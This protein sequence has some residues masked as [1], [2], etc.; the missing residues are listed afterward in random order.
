M[1]LASSGRLSARGAR[2]GWPLRSFG[3]RGPLPVPP[4][5]AAGLA[6]SPPPP[7][8]LHAA[9]S[10]ASAVTAP[11]ADGYGA[12]SFPAS[13]ASAGSQHFATACAAD[14]SGSPFP[15]SGPVAS[16][17][18]SPSRRSISC[19]ASP[20]CSPQ[21]FPCAPEALLG[22]CVPL[23]P[24][25]TRGKVNVSRSAAS[26]AS[27]AALPPFC[28][29]VAAVSPLVHT[30]S[31]CL[32]PFVPSASPATRVPSGLEVSTP[33]DDSSSGRTSFESSP[34]SSA[35]LLSG[36]TRR[37]LGGGSPPQSAAAGAAVATADGC[38]SREQVAACLS[39]SSSFV[40][41]AAYHDC[42]QLRC[43]YSC[44]YSHLSN[45]VFLLHVPALLFV[46]QCAR[47]SPP[48]PGARLD[49]GQAR[50]DSS[51]SLLR[52]C[53]LSSF[54]SS[55]SAP[56]APRQY[57]E[58]GRRFKTRVL[59]DGSVGSF[60]PECATAAWGPQGEFAQGDEGRLA[61]S[62]SREVPRRRRSYVRQLSCYSL[63]REGC[64]PPPLGDRGGSPW[65]LAPCYLGDSRG[66]ALS[67]EELLQA[68][69]DGRS[70]HSLPSS[71]LEA[72][73]G[74]R[75]LP[76]ALTAQ[77]SPLGDTFLSAE[78]A[79]AAPP[80]PSLLL[81]LLAEV[82]PAPFPSLWPPLVLLLQK[83]EGSDEL[84]SGGGESRK[85]PRRRTPKRVSPPGT[86]RGHLSADPDAS[87]V[88]LREPPTAGAAGALSRGA[89]SVS[90]SAASGVL[91]LGHAYAM[92]V[93]AHLGAV[94]S[95]QLHSATA[96][97]ALLLFAQVEGW[98][99][100]VWREREPC[101]GSME[102][103]VR[104]ELP[105]PSPA[106][107]PLSRAG[108]EAPE[109]GEL[110][111]GDDC[112][113]RRRKIGR[114]RP[115][116]AA[117]AEEGE[118]D[119]RGSPQR[120]EREKI[121]KEQGTTWP[122][123][124]D[125]RRVARV[126][127]LE[128]D[129][130]TQ[131]LGGSGLSSLD[132]GLTDSS[133]FAA[134]PRQHILFLYLAAEPRLESDVSFFFPCA[135][136][137]RSPADD[138][139]GDDDVEGGDFEAADVGEGRKRCRGRDAG[140][141]KEG[142]RF[143]GAFMV[144]GLA[145]GA[146]GR[147]V[148]Q[149]VAGPA[150][151]P[152]DATGLDI[153]EIEKAELCEISLMTSFLTVSSSSSCPPV[154]SG[155]VV[156]APVR[157]GLPLSG[158]S[159]SIPPLI[160]SCQ[161]PG[162]STHRPASSATASAS[163]AVAAVGGNLAW[164]ELTGLL[165]SAIPPCRL[166]VRTGAR[167]QAVLLVSPLFL[168]C[169]PEASPASRERALPRAADRAAGLS[170][171]EP[172][173]PQ[174]P[175]CSPSAGAAGWAACSPQ[176][177][178]PVGPALHYSLRCL[179]S[180]SRTF[181]PAS[182][183][184]RASLA[185]LWPPFMHA[186]LLR[187]LSSLA[188][189]V[190]PSALC[191]LPLQ[192]NLSKASSTVSA[193]P[194]PKQSL[195]L[196]PSS[197]LPL[198]SSSPCLLAAAAGD[199]E[200]A[201]A[202]PSPRGG[203]APAAQPLGLRSPSL[204]RGNAA[205]AFSLSPPSRLLSPGAA[206]V[207]DAASVTTEGSGACL[208]DLG[209][210]PAAP[211]G[212]RPPSASVS[213]S[214]SG[215]RAPPSFL[216]L[217][218][219]P[220][221][222]VAAGLVA[223]PAWASGPSG[224]EPR[225]V[226]F[227][228]HYSDMLAGSPPV[229]CLQSLTVP[230]GDPGD[231]FAAGDRRSRNK[232][233]ALKQ[234]YRRLPLMSAVYWLP[235][236]SLSLF[237][238]ACRDSSAERLSPEGGGEEATADVPLRFF[239]R[240]GEEA[241]LRNS[242]IG[243][244]GGSRRGGALDMIGGQLPVLVCVAAE[245]LRDNRGTKRAKSGGRRPCLYVFEVDLLHS[246]FGIR[247]VSL[248]F[249][250]APG[251]LP[252]PISQVLPVSSSR[253]D[254]SPLPSGG[255]DP[256]KSRI[257][258]S[259][260]VVASQ[261]LELSASFLSH[262][263]RSHML[264]VLLV[265]E[266]SEAVARA[267]SGCVQTDFVS[268]RGD[269]ACE[270]A[271][272]SRSADRGGP[273]DAEQALV[274]KRTSS[275]SSLVS[276]LLP[277]SYS[278]LVYAI[279]TPRSA[280]GGSRPPTAR[281]EGGCA[282]SGGVTSE[283]VEAGSGCSK[284][285][286]FVGL[287]SA[288]CLSFE[289]LGRWS[290]AGC[291][292]M[293]AAFGGYASGKPVFSACV[294]SSS[295]LLLASPLFF[296]AAASAGTM[297]SQ[298]ALLSSAP[299]QM[300]SSGALLAGAAAAHGRHTAGASIEPEASGKTDA[301]EKC[302]LFLLQ[303]PKPPSASQ[304]RLREAARGG[305]APS[306]LS[307]GDEEDTETP[308][309]LHALSRLSLFAVAALPRDRRVTAVALAPDSLAVGTSFKQ[310]ANGGGGG[311][312]P[313]TA[314]QTRVPVA[315]VFGLRGL[316]LVVP[317]SLE[318]AGSGQSVASTPLAQ[319][320]IGAES[321]TTLA[322]MRAA[323]AHASQLQPEAA[324]PL[325]GFAREVL[326][327]DQSGAGDRAAGSGTTSSLSASSAPR[328]CK[329]FLHQSVRTTR[330]AAGPRA[331][332]SSAFGRLSS[333]RWRT[334]IQTLAS[335]ADAGEEQQH[336]EL[337][338]GPN[339]DQMETGA[340]GRPSGAVSAVQ[341]GAGCALP[342]SLH[343]VV[344]LAFC[345]L[346]GAALGLLAKTASPQAAQGRG[347]QQQGTGEG[348]MYLFVCVSAAQ[349]RRASGFGTGACSSAAQRM[350][351]VW[352]R[353]LPLPPEDCLPPEAQH[354]AFYGHP[355][356]SGL[357]DAWWSSEPGSLLAFLALPPSAPGAADLAAGP[358]GFGSVAPWGEDAG[359]TSGAAAGSAPDPL[360]HHA[361]G[362]LCSLA[363]S[364]AAA[365][366]AAACSWDLRL[367]VEAD[368]ARRRERNAS[369]SS[370]DASLS[371]QVLG[372][373]QR[374]SL[375]SLLCFLLPIGARP[376]AP[377]SG[378]PSACL[379]HAKAHERLHPPTASGLV[380]PTNTA[381]ATVASVASPAAAARAA[382][383][384]LA[385]Q[386]EHEEAE[387]RLLQ[388]VS[389]PLLLLYHPAVLD[390]L[391]SSG[392]VGTVKWILGTLL[393][394]LRA[395]GVARA[396]ESLQRKKDGR[397]AENASA[398][399][400]T[401]ILLGGFMWESSSKGPGGG[402][403]S[404]EC[405]WDASPPD[406]AD[407]G[408]TPGG[409]GAATSE[410]LEGAE[411]ACCCCGDRGDTE[412]CSCCCV[413]QTLLDTSMMCLSGIFLQ[414]AAEEHEL[415]AARR[416]GDSGKGGSEV[417]STGF[418]SRGAPD[419]AADCALGVGS[420]VTG[421]GHGAGRL[422][423]AAETH[424]PE[425]RREAFYAALL[426]RC[427]VA[428]RGLV[429][430]ME[431]V[432][433]DP[434][435]DAD[436]V[437]G[438]TSE[439]GFRGSDV[440]SGLG[441]VRQQ[442]PFEFGG[443][444]SGAAARKE[445]GRAEDLFGSSSSVLED[446]DPFDV[447]DL[448]GLGGGKKKKEE[449][450]SLFSAPRDYVTSALQHQ[451]Q[452][453]QGGASAAP[454]SVSPCHLS[455]T[456]LDPVVVAL[457]PADYD[458]LL[459]LLGV[460][461]PGLRLTGP[462]RRHLWGFVAALRSLEGGQLER[463]ETPVNSLL[464]DFPAV[465]AA[466]FEAA[467]AA[468][469]ALA[470]GVAKSEARPLAD[471]EGARGFV[472]QGFGCRSLED[473]STPRTA[474]TQD[475][476]PARGHDEV[477]ERENGPLTPGDEEAREGELAAA[478]VAADKLRGRT[479]RAS[480][481]AS[482]GGKRRK[483]G[484]LDKEAC[485]ARARMG[486]LQVAVSEEAA[487]EVAEQQ[488][489]AHQPLRAKLAMAA[490]LFTAPEK[491]SPVS[492]PE[493]G[494]SP[495]SLLLSSEDL[496]WCLQADGEG[497][498]LAEAVAS[499]RKS[500]RGKLLWPHI[501]KRGVGFWLRSTTQVRALGDWLLKDATVLAAAETAAQQG[502]FG[503]PHAGG[504]GDKET[505]AL[506][507]LSSYASSASVQMPS[508]DSS[509][510]AV[511]PFHRSD[512]AAL[513]S[514][515]S[516]RLSFIK[517]AYKQQKN[518]KVVE[519]LS[520]DFSDPRAQAAAEKNAYKLVQQRRYHLALAFFILAKKIREVCDLCCRQLQD[521][522]LALFL[523]R[524]IDATQRP[525]GP[526]LG[527][528]PFSVSAS[529]FCSPSVAS[530]HTVAASPG[531]LGPRG[532]KASSPSALLSLPPP[533][534]GALSLSP[535]PLPSSPPTLSE[536]GGAVAHGGARSPSDGA[537]PLASSSSS[538][539]PLTEYRRVLLQRLAPLA[540]EAG[541]VWLLHLALWL[542]GDYQAALFVLL[543]PHL[544]PSF[545]RLA[546]HAHA[547]PP[548]AGAS[549]G[550]ADAVSVPEGR[551][552]CWLADGSDVSAV[553][554]FHPRLFFSACEDSAVAV[555]PSHLFERLP[556]P[557]GALCPPGS[558]QGV[559]PARLGSGQPKHAP[560]A[561]R[562]VF[563]FLSHVA[564]GR[565]DAGERHTAAHSGPHADR[566]DG[567]T[568][569]HSQLSLSLV[570]F[571][572]VVLNTLP[573]QRLRAE[574][575]QQHAQLQLVR[576]LCAQLQSR[577][578]APGSQG[579]NSLSPSAARQTGH[580][581]A[582]GG[583]DGGHA[584]A[585]RPPPNGGERLRGA[586]AP[587][588][589]GGGASPVESPRGGS[590]SAPR[591]GSGTFSL[592]SA[593]SSLGSSPPSGPAHGAAQP[594]F[595]LFHHSSASTLDALS[596]TTR[597][598]YSDVGTGAGGSGTQRGPRGEG[599]AGEEA[600]DGEDGERG[601][602]RD[603]AGVG[604]GG[605]GAGEP[606]EPGLSRA[607]SGW[608]AP[609][610][611]SSPPAA[612]PTE[613]LDL[614]VVGRAS[615]E[616]FT[617]ARVSR[618]DRPDAA[619]GV[620][621][622][623]EL[624]EAACV[625]EACLWALKNPSAAA[626]CEF[627]LLTLAYLHQRQAFLAS[628]ASASFLALARV[629]DG[630]VEEEA[631]KTTRRG[632][633]LGARG[634]E[635]DAV[636]ECGGKRAAA[637]LTGEGQEPHG[638][639]ERLS[640]ATDIRMHSFVARRWVPTAQ[641]AFEL[642]FASW[643][644]CLTMD[645]SLRST[646][647]AL[648]IRVPLPEEI[649]TQK[650]EAG[651]PASRSSS[652]CELT[653][654]NVGTL[655]LLPESP[656]ASLL[657]RLAAPEPCRSC[658]LCGVSSA[659]VGPSASR[660]TVSL[661][662][663]D[664]IASCLVAFVGCLCE[665]ADFLR[666]VLD[667]ALLSSSSLG[668][669]GARRSA[670]AFPCSPRCVCCRAG[671]AGPS[672]EASP[673]A[674]H[675][676][677]LAPSLAAAP[678]PSGGDLASRN[679]SVGSVRAASPNP[680]R[681][682]GVLDAVVSQLLLWS[683]RRRRSSALAGLSADAAGG[684]VRRRGPA[685]CSCAEKRLLQAIQAAEKIGGGRRLTA[686]AAGAMA[687]AA[688]A[689]P[690]AGAVRE[691]RLLRRLCQCGEGA[692][693][694]DD[695]SAED[696]GPPRGR[697]TD[698]ACSGAA[699]AAGGT[700]QDASASFSSLEPPLWALAATFGSRV[701][702][703]FE[704]DTRHLASGCFLAAVRAAALG[705]RAAAAARRRT[706]TPSGGAE[707]GASR[708]AVSRRGRR[709]AWRLA[710][711]CAAA[712]VRSEVL[713]DLSWNREVQTVLHTYLDG[714]DEA[715]V[716]A[717]SGR[718]GASPRNATLWGMRDALERGEAFS[719]R[720]AT[721][722]LAKELIAI[723]SAPER[724]LFDSL[725]IFCCTAAAAASLDIASALEHALPVCPRAGEGVE[726]RAGGAD[727]L[728]VCASC[729]RHR[730]DRADSHALGMARPT[731]AVLSLEHLERL[732]QLSVVALGCVC[733]CLSAAFPSL[734]L[735]FSLHPSTHTGAH[736]SSPSGGGACGGSASHLSAD[737]R[738]GHEERAY[739]RSVSS[740][741][742]TEAAE[743][744]AE[745][746]GETAKAAEDKGAPE[747]RHA[748]H[749]DGGDEA[750]D[751]EFNP[752]G[753]IL[754]I[755]V[756]LHCILMQPKRSTWVCELRRH[757]R[758]FLWPRAASCARKNS[759]AEDAESSRTGSTAEDA[760]GVS[761]RSRARRERDAAR[762]RKSS[763]AFPTSS[764]LL[765]CLAACLSVKVFEFLLDLLRA[766][767][768][769]ALRLLHFFQLLALASASPGGESR[770]A[771]PKDGESEGEMPL[772]GRAE[773]VA[774]G[775]LL[776]MSSFPV[777]HLS[778]ALTPPETGGVAAAGHQAASL[779]LQE[780]QIRLL[781]GW[782]DRL[783]FSLSSFV[784]SHL[785]PLLTR[786]APLSASL[787]L[788]LLCSSDPPSL[789]GV[790]GLE[791][792]WAR[793]ETHEPA[794]SSRSFMDNCF[795]L[796]TG[797]TKGPL[798]CRSIS[799]LLGPDAA[800][801]WI[802]LGC[803]ARLQWLFGQLPF[804]PL[805]QPLP[806]S[807]PASPG[808]SAPSHA[809][810]QGTAKGGSATGAGS[811]AHLGGGAVGETFQKPAAP[812]ATSRAAR[813]DAPLGG[814]EGRGVWGSAGGRTGKKPAVVVGGATSRMQLQQQLVRAGIPHL[815][816][817]EGR[818]QVVQK[819]GAGSGP[820]L[821]RLQQHVLAELPSLRLADE[822]VV[823]GAAP[824]VPCVLGGVFPPGKICSVAASRPRTNAVEA[825]RKTYEHHLPSFLTPEAVALLLAEAV[826]SQR[827][828]RSAAAETPVGSSKPA[829]N[830]AP[831]PF[832]PLSSARSLPRASRPWGT[833]P[834][835]WWSSPCCWVPIA[836]VLGPVTVAC[837]GSSH[838]RYFLPAGA[839][840]STDLAVGVGPLEGLTVTGGAGGAA[841]NSS[842]ALRTIRIPP[843]L[844][845]AS[846][847]GGGA[848]TASLLYGAAAAVHAAAAATAAVAA[849]AE[850]RGDLLLL[851]P[852]KGAPKAV[853][854]PVED[855]EE[856]PGSR[857]AA[858]G[859]GSPP[860]AP[861]VGSAEGAPG[862]PP[863][864]G[865][866]EQVDPA[867]PENVKEEGEAS[868]PRGG[869]FEAFKAEARWLLSVTSPLMS[870]SRCPG[871][872]FVGIAPLRRATVNSSQH[873]Q[874]RLTRILARYRHHR[875]ETDSRWPGRHEASKRAP[876]SPGGG[877][878]AALVET[879]SLLNAS[880]SEGSVLLSVWFGYLLTRDTSLFAYAQVDRMSAAMRL[881]AVAAAA[882]G[883]ASR[884]TPP[885]GS[886]APGLAS[887]G[888][889]AGGAKDLAVSLP[890]SGGL[891]HPA[892]HPRASLAASLE[893]TFPYQAFPS[894]SVLRSCFSFTG[895]VSGHPFLPIFAAVLQAV[896][897]QA[898]PATAFG[899]ILRPFGAHARSLPKASSP[900]LPESSREAPSTASGD[901]NGRQ[902]EPAEAHVGARSRPSGFEAAAHAESSPRGDQPE[903]TGAGAKAGEGDS[904][905]SGPSSSVLRAGST[906]ANG[907]LQRVQT[908]QLPREQ[909]DL[910][911]FAR[912]RSA[913]GSFPF[914]R[915]AIAE[916]AKAAASSGPPGSGRGAAASAAGASASS[917]GGA[918]AGSASRGRPQ[919][920]L[921]CFGRVT[922]V[923]W[924]ESGDSLFM[925]DSTGWIRV[926]GLLRGPLLPP[927]AAVAVAAAGAESGPSSRLGI[928]SAS[929]RGAGHHHHV[930]APTPA[931][932]EGMLS[933]AVQQVT[934]PAVAWRGH[935]STE[936]VLPLHGC[937]SWLLTRGVGLFPHAV[938]HNPVLVEGSPF[939][940]GAEGP[941]LGLPPAH[942]KPR[943]GAAGAA[944]HADF[945]YRRGGGGGDRDG[946]RDSARRSVS[947]GVGRATGEGRRHAEDDD[948]AYEEGSDEPGAMS[949]DSGGALL[950]HP[951]RMSVHNG[952]SSTNSA[953]EGGNLGARL[954]IRHPTPPG[955]NRASMVV[956]QLHGQQRAGG[957]DS[958]DRACD[959]TRERRRHGLEVPESPSGTSGD[960]K[961]WR[962]HN[963]HPFSIFR[964]GRG[965]GC[966]EAADAAAAGGG[967][968]RLRAARLAL[969]RRDSGSAE[970]EKEGAEDVP[971]GAARRRRSL[972][973]LPSTARRRFKGT[974]II[975]KI[976]A[977]LAQYQTQ[978]QQ[979]YGSSQHLPRKASQRAAGGAWHVEPSSGVE[980]T[981]SPPSSVGGVSS[982]GYAYAATATSGLIGPGGFQASL[983]S[984]SALYSGSLRSGG[985]LG[986]EED[987][988]AGSV[989]ALSSTLPLQQWTS[990]V[991]S[992][993][994]AGE[995]SEDEE[996]RLGVRDRLLGGDFQ[997]MPRISGP[998]ICLWDLWDITAGGGPRLDC[999]I[1000]CDDL[1001]L[1002]RV[1003][1004]QLASA[1005]GSKSSLGAP[1006]SSKRASKLKKGSQ[1007]A[1008]G[1009]VE[1010]S[1011]ETWEVVAT[1012]T[1013]TCMGVAVLQD[1014]PEVCSCCSAAASGG[1015]GCAAPGAEVCGAAWASRAWGSGRQADATACGG[1016]PS[1017]C[1018]AGSSCR[1019]CSWCCGSMRC[1020]LYGDADGAVHAVD[1021]S[1022]Q[1023]EVYRWQ[1024]HP[1025]A[1026]V[1027]C[1028]VSRPAAA[1029]PSHVS[1030]IPAS[1031][1032]VTAASAPA[1033]DATFRC[1034]SLSALQGGPPFLLYEFTSPGHVPLPLGAAGA[1035]GRALGGLVGTQTAG[1036]LRDEGAAARFGGLGAGAGSTPGVVVGSV[1037]S[1038][1039]Q[1040]RRMLGDETWQG[1041]AGDRSDVVQQG[1042]QPT[1043]SVS[1044][1045][1046][1047]FAPSSVNALVR[1048]L[1049]VEG[1050]EAKASPA[1051]AQ[1052]D[1053]SVA[1054]SQVVGP[1055]S[1056]LTVRQDGIV[1057]LNRL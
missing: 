444:S 335:H 80:A 1039:P 934:R 367:C 109:D 566:F 17:P 313:A 637:A 362:A 330:G 707:T 451:S 437:P 857:E 796:P 655:L 469:E 474:V 827:P 370:A 804:L 921:Q 499:A 250:L 347:A 153:V 790:S 1025:S 213:S 524:L 915:T 56:P 753:T 1019:C 858:A 129:E 865:L 13:V 734:A 151:V 814:G 909:A 1013:P 1000:T 132:F 209:R 463:G 1037:N 482:Q 635:R 118:G 850:Y 8:S 765:Q 1044:P 684:G 651:S 670:T 471:R 853:S 174:L 1035:R 616:S 632:Q 156:G 923:A 293:R 36:G 846:P 562:P 424:G 593:P 549:R 64:A 764:S 498:M 419:Q 290:A 489:A 505:P 58:R 1003:Q 717:R 327:K 193:L 542:A 218:V 32:V 86:P 381:A 396:R 418:S 946:G 773:T 496:C 29:T 831:P 787:L 91:I 568:L 1040:E 929:S 750:A 696:C 308:F 312:R 977:R 89:A 122:S 894:L 1012:H 933:A 477:P 398:G 819:Q 441:S 896:E 732:L 667:R 211:T 389:P 282:A 400:E 780:R 706:G 811:P 558:A 22:A 991:F 3:A 693:E 943:A 710:R 837:C 246:L 990:G 1052:A 42:A 507:S 621:S 731:S 738:V 493:K 881:L 733:L 143:I 795:V 74:P 115:D 851:A 588:A 740:A 464:T 35:S 395:A 425:K 596:D 892:G 92:S 291:A 177:S 1027:A 90:A 276:R 379:P 940:S 799:V 913:A 538:S 450:M 781:R 280:A 310:V 859:S 372:T 570:S 925:A 307:R 1053:E 506:A 95:V 590:F 544:P 96:C 993:G 553:A 173:R 237:Q 970:M 907:F 697:A 904:Q 658:F 328:K 2:A 301:G 1005:T 766:I 705:R 520:R 354:Q 838:R 28:V 645:R 602:R 889:P 168:C 902:P 565:A 1031:W 964:R 300:P 40:Y 584:A 746:A 439:G 515:A 65:P 720:G 547:P 636:F 360:P 114:R 187:P 447:S 468:A 586:G 317:V 1021:L 656:I 373:I 359:D 190:T 711:F 930:A 772:Q 286:A 748:Q 195:A 540:A 116:G 175:R 119:L 888:A 369:V 965:K 1023:E 409:A 1020:V 180:V 465:A 661:S 630:G 613:D 303:L 457:S 212:K 694:S 582:A 368:A 571:R 998:C 564:A 691:Q 149:R 284:A 741:A 513:W 19:V 843:I 752:L 414:L 279:G 862:A 4:P 242:G 492:A 951:M 374:F 572:A 268:Q 681:A 205:S 792:S 747:A 287:R 863:E 906:A 421:R 834:V 911:E 1051:P 718:P 634:D 922:C 663:A 256:P 876:S 105:L 12:L 103:A 809:G 627:Y 423:G 782:V 146:V 386:R 650:E 802:L 716:R 226:V 266:R 605:L 657:S 329:S 1007:A 185:S 77:S 494:S 361:P 728:F 617:P 133:P 702:S 551:T 106:A 139:E 592:V 488:S 739:Q 288:G 71:L 890:G 82:L 801:L 952:A 640:D 726:N 532:L 646:D 167:D 994:G 68:D 950:K 595:H 530:A 522:Q 162:L 341:E 247:P 196:P 306:V 971:L 798:L 856:L 908:T 760:Q 33:G 722:V 127:V 818:P 962:G 729:S 443:L 609:H 1041:R 271:S 742:A 960:A 417:R 391:F 1049:G 875:S 687:W 848:C 383:A 504:D 285:D 429:G 85:D 623:V 966:C 985:G 886:G 9:L 891:A 123:S 323:V 365:A 257:R 546:S 758:D 606:A 516:D 1033:A 230:S 583:V 402:E 475:L 104:I 825:L 895:S 358:D 364:P 939:V 882:S 1010:S 411:A 514:V 501:K 433:D 995:Q 445:G 432:Q 197:G 393:R 47:P 976:Q 629:G 992:F 916:L 770:A 638:A 751:R 771:S 434:P 407:A 763:H 101:S 662:L 388:L 620:A 223:P 901:A 519:F 128:L 431:N 883:G 158:L 844:L 866:T 832:T 947:V 988:E 126:A 442:S 302:F 808:V 188:S 229:C 430:G 182:L 184:S 744:D 189:S 97:T 73:A 567:G 108:G 350:P 786:A 378:A 614:R 178:P 665:D 491:P 526:P 10:S 512:V 155:V 679:S 255:S 628:V 961:A 724:Q 117:D 18:H 240:G 855:A 719:A 455:E 397:A 75:A 172:D 521:V 563:P 686:I 1045:F 377:L 806:P 893:P 113:K 885:S 784:C 136:A 137:R 972:R 619:D 762:R 78:S 873:L 265:E 937:G 626:A 48:S 53:S 1001:L 1011:G 975:A 401:T 233:A 7:S 461:V 161:Q 1034:W 812:G 479:L 709:D 783:S 660:R 1030:S 575:E 1022:L 601:R 311:E 840:I 422:S 639:G 93:C 974:D 456:S 325:L 130:R 283:E 245:E 392:L 712:W 723:F 500:A 847:S 244:E 884:S 84:E 194:A 249:S 148:V 803:T 969:R 154:A 1024:A 454:S 984:G 163:A 467:G 318:T 344:R 232:A 510:A 578:V 649:F 529:L 224:E 228:W 24:A 66:W 1036:T 142:F 690:V 320:S 918:A 349:L 472:A 191:L 899:V 110:W 72:G 920:Q 235:A 761:S 573:I 791:A 823:S 671:L 299:S 869:R 186:G 473:R 416:R 458:L 810:G 480:T 70:S 556:S 878:P 887:P 824:G 642:L 817:S 39:L 289:L 633:C 677:G 258:F 352:L 346:P 924:S 767:D 683:D 338:K 534:S 1048:L 220:E 610:L 296:H 874:R 253:L 315:F 836:A 821:S 509:S 292:D 124:R 277:A 999:V 76:R 324:L 241:P 560:E 107:A 446:D 653:G 579:G 99:V 533:S 917:S 1055:A 497:A 517:T 387:L 267:S 98:G 664:A 481:A 502:A 618:S 518:T 967:V 557:L 131:G 830:G 769:E 337:A 958:A 880:W 192:Q 919:G 849:A 470:G 152:L 476:A 251:S 774:F 689:G 644:P 281:P 55:P 794:R 523:C 238:R 1042:Q 309:S 14:S 405:P 845:G 868:R 543:P 589:L 87:Q 503:A 69:E 835:P 905:A 487:V 234:R 615:S 305:L 37:A 938:R 944:G 484:K 59:A 490:S 926:Y 121:C 30:S 269:S 643:A 955:R 404:A 21:V 545:A 797:N 789:G 996:E 903:E 1050:R 820:A 204:S 508:S 176:A 585:L 252:W 298:S 704:E 597:G 448:L 721:A 483:G 208:Q 138:G 982:S 462:E 1054:M 957:R 587:Q 478:R 754:H 528:D 41:A 394:C 535:S 941:A 1029:C 673:P 321:R 332:L 217:E 314:P 261:A 581:A 987:S 983:S 877:F 603:A 403:V 541:D 214:P 779:R 554:P 1043:Q 166:T 275:A 11:H 963:H 968:T 260:R 672:E 805:Q 179:S 248:S 980:A 730:E 829:G 1057:L 598:D 793:E 759:A 102:L 60:P 221:F 641:A 79:A 674:A 202:G 27:P 692:D 625:G 31:A 63:S 833:S 511:N 67:A 319:D 62:P 945:V 1014:C 26:S 986:P 351:P 700:Q 822:L 222:N 973:M 331:G 1006:G 81:S 273:Q 333:R 34:P 815:L 141:K 867:R 363:S 1009:G 912:G 412:L 15:V 410:A 436:A 725:A 371:F 604:H 198:S 914:D 675:G 577:P 6:G 262:S 550:F 334:Q 713:L 326:H 44:I 297:H 816:L 864:T 536:A 537:A 685:G 83:L 776:K 88:A 548:G 682:L 594:P 183:A 120:R 828:H 20:A 910:S 552:H 466:A 206:S 936:E 254:L 1038:C 385:R 406:E 236:S 274:P 979:R 1046:S 340:A 203:P 785:R 140:R 599:G 485:L 757:L 5:E 57:V 897:L 756:Y 427:G 680:V 813:P 215:P 264:L 413:L 576:E 555:S 420:P 569:R 745:S 159:S 316:P 622:G 928:G 854:N 611:P 435:R 272:R 343:Q 150:Q 452:R 243:E 449:A 353:L 61:F 355:L 1016:S 800:Q 942:A 45:E 735:F 49:R 981:V 668:A 652:L 879:S 749:D 669:A 949:G 727:G 1018:A 647:A 807:R 699:G 935:V 871:G 695:E 956:E 1015:C 931:Q 989:G 336:D 1017:A 157:G 23:P 872:A 357:R 898:S 170:G 181:L 38:L 415:L 997:Q 25:A 199:E 227:L 861:T 54:S 207:P 135:G 356:V 210:S 1008:G 561:H 165:A 715:R 339:G 200:G 342:C 612:G 743:T 1004:Q 608:S 145:R 111:S 678:V 788:P 219:L 440:L 559:P 607:G 580:A 775:T 777:P 348:F 428:G 408:Q 539:C 239:G 382:A 390:A 51:G 852:R 842:Y 125:D 160:G 50:A 376:W 304:G 345:R 259:A 527:S 270:P 459:L 294:L 953:G 826:A 231:G 737:A 453:S 1002:T 1056:I 100:H 708:L 495:S 169:A 959:R 778:R 134:I 698:A 366:G 144:D 714:E 900:A 171:D 94:R 927:S 147:P 112:H 531:L 322:A 52:L 380:N 654:L 839:A 703:F 384:A 438:F 768:R 525:C 1047:P 631:E 426:R 46:Q 954:V 591:Q 278:L 164:G 688:G 216:S 295:T 948:S 1:S 932:K 225:G 574:L 978:F 1028:R 870:E 624:T 841:S 659:Q 701:P 736:V 600:R 1026:V 1032:L 201:S 486:L 43:P 648:Q 16:A 460:G 375:H 676:A 755:V 399:S 860:E 263:L 666:P